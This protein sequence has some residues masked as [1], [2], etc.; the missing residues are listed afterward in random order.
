[1]EFHCGCAGGGE[2]RRT[3]LGLDSTAFCRY[4]TTSPGL[5]EPLPAKMRPSAYRAPPSEYGELEPADG[6]EGVGYPTPHC[7]A[8]VCTRGM[9]GVGRYGSRTFIAAS[10]LPL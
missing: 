6:R 5:E 1:M 8:E 10:R 4:A 9:P 2:R 7:A 3:S